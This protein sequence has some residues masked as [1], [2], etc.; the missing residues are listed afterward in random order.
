MTAC[1]QNRECLFGNVVEGQM[2]LN[3]AGEM[4][5][6]QWK[7]LGEI[8]GVEVDEHVVMP[9]HIHGIVSL[10][11]GQSENTTVPL[12]MNRFKSLTTVE[13]IR[14]VRCFAFDPFASRLWQRGYHDRVIRSDDE[15]FRV[16]E[17]IRN[18]PA[19]WASDDFNQP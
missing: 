12:L 19:N 11:E 16:R 13:Y 17:Y 18:N 1:I 2:I 6:H 4:V 8:P 9:N 7:L 15:L 14:G 10:I 3:G 5:D